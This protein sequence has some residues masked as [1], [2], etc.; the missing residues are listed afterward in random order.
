MTDHDDTT[1]RLPT[2]R[3]PEQKIEDLKHYAETADKA[4]ARQQRHAESQDRWIESLK[5]DVKAA[6]STQH[7]LMEEIHS[8]HMEYRGSE[9]C[10]TC[11]GRGTVTEMVHANYPSRTNEW[12]PAE[13][14]EEVE[15]EDCL[16]TG[17]SWLT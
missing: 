13:V 9:E 6:R 17:K 5:A 1:G 15:C 3:T 8:L 16:G 2:H 11:G 12:E 14:P 10:E 4:L 7:R